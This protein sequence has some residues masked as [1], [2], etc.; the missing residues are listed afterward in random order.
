M[1]MRACYLQGQQKIIYHYVLSIKAQFP[2]DGEELQ[3]RLQSDI[4]INSLLRQK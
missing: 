4:N 3:A 1:V 2:F